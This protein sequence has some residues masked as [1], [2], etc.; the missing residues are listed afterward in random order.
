MNIDA[1]FE[2]IGKYAED[3]TVVIPTRKTKE[4]AGY[5]FCAAEDVVIYPFTSEEWQDQVA[6]GISRHFVT[7]DAYAE[8]L[9]LTLAETASV[10]K[11]GNCKV[12][13]VP[14][15]IKCK[16][17]DGHYLQLSVRSSLPL[18]H[19]LILGNGVGIIDADYYNNP[20]NEGHIYFQIINLAPFPIKIQRGECFGQ[21]ILLPYCTAEEEEVTTERD[22]GFG[23]TSEK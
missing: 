19:W 15:G 20:D 14:T 6:H 23:S 4:S 13:L 3:P 2:K 22:G 17:P 1:K 12:N 7:M 11:L 18:K 5:D 16:I 10:M 8:A 21:G 9:P